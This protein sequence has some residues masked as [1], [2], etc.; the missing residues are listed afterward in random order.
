M[1]SGRQFGLP[2]GDEL[3]DAW[4][5][6]NPLC[7]RILCPLSP[8]STQVASPHH[9]LCHIVSVGCFVCVSC[10]VSFDFYTGGWLLCF[11]TQCDSGY[12]SFIICLQ[13]YVPAGALLGKYLVPFI[14][15]T[16]GHAI[17]VRS[18]RQMRH[19][20]FDSRILHSV[21]TNLSA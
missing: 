14:F 17:C 10:I 15:C 5:W 3:C 18:Y 8:S 9:Q 16:N 6:D 12:T 13:L 20:H 11:S 4:T 21:P 1:R 2:G 7:R 19:L